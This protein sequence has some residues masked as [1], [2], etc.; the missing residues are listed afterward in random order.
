MNKKLSNTIKYL[1]IGNFLLVFNWILLLNSAPLSGQE[2][3]GYEI[4]F[5]GQILFGLFLFT[6][7]S[8]RARPNVETHVVLSPQAVEACGD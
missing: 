4:F 3:L 1:V 8:W 6:L 7:R 5:F 2:I